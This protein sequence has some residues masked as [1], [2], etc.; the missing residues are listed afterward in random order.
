MKYILFD[1]DGTLSDS[2]E[3]IINT[4][5]YTINELNYPVPEDKVI[6]TFIGPP[7][8]E[9]FKNTFGMSEEETRRAVQIFRPYYGKN[10]MFQNE[11]YQGIEEML[12]TL[13]Q[14]GYMMGIATSKPEVYAVK[15]LENFGI[16]HYFDVIVGAS[17][18][19]K[20]SKKYDIMELAIKKAREI[21]DIDE[22]TMVGDRSYDMESSVKLGVE[23]IGVTYGFGSE[24][25]VRS[26]G[27]NV[28]CHKPS[29]I[30]QYLLNKK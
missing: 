29:E 3:G 28:V 26:T 1:L 8:V 10:G 5:K 19:D 24:E 20:F 23:A 13:K 18:D 17:L 14:A 2:S 9:T 6:Y 30:T 22:I 15:I 16:A 4:F 27:A 25:E 11:L 7:I 21:E 12:E